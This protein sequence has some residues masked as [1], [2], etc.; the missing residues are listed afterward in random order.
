MNFMFRLAL[1]CF[2]MSLLPVSQ[3][4]KAEVFANSDSAF[5]KD[6]FY[7]IG[8]SLNW[9]SQNRE[10]FS[11]P[12]FLL[13]QK[14]QSFKADTYALDFKISSRF[15][16]DAG[17]ELTI[18]VIYKNSEIH[19]SPFYLSPVN[20]ADIPKANLKGT[21]IGDITAVFKYRA[22]EYENLDLI[23]VAGFSIPGDDSPAS[24]Y[25]AEKTPLSMG[26]NSIITGLAFNFESGSLFASA[27][28]NYHYYNGNALSYL[29]VADGRTIFNG[30]TAPFDRF[31]NKALISFNISDK[32]SLKLKA[33]FDLVFLPPLKSG[34]SWIAYSSTDRLNF[35][36]AAPGISYALSSHTFI[37]AGYFLAIIDDSA[38]NP[39]YSIMRRK[40]GLYCDL[41]FYSF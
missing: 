9:Y 28:T 17:V 15:Y 24:D 40:L 33:D 39:F 26:L 41:K 25:S 16:K 10:D 2:C 34:S 20:K 18:P 8:L 22:L 30:S 36:S 6:T 14:A 27:E 3:N 31:K 4:L 12:V 38:M 32:L 37:E 13:N 23:L 29:K 1:L 35:L 11:D 21:G 7:N 19:Y 5:D